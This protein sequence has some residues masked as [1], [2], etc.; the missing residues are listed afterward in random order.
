MA[1]STTTLAAAVAA[2]ASQIALASTSAV[3]VGD[4]LFVDGEAMAVVGLISPANVTVMR[5]AAGTKG[6]DHATSLTVYVGKPHQFYSQD[7]VGKPP[8]NPQNTPWINLRTGA[9]WTVSGSAWVQTVSLTGATLTSPTLTSPTLTTPTLTSPT[10]TGPIQQNAAAG[11]A[12]AMTEAVSSHVLADNTVVD[13]FTVTVPNAI[14]GAA[15]QLFVTSTLGDG[16]ST[17]SA[18]YNLAI[19]RITGA[20][21]KAV[22]SSK[23]GTGATAGATGN[24][25]ITASVSAMSGAVGVAQT[26]TIQFKN[27][28]SAGTATNHP[29]FAIANLV[30]E[31]ASG[32]TIV[33]A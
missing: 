21:T 4:L 16:D 33:A 7:P 11:G 25:V 13:F 5:G 22:L 19:S 17:D 2:S 8:L 14:H 31:N 15:I 9:I 6:L 3:S 20:A 32:V 24:A 27:A 18:T 10:I 30:N 26:F 23:T 12:G 29:T 1:L 28:R